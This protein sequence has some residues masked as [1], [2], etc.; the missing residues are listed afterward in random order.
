MLCRVTTVAKEIIAVVIVVLLL[1]VL[2]VRSHNLA[3]KNKDDDEEETVAV[4]EEEDINAIQEH[5][6]YTANLGID[7]KGDGRVEVKE[8]TAQ[9][10]QQSNVQQVEATYGDAISVFDFRKVPDK[11]VDGSSIKDYLK[12]VSAMDFE[13]GWGKELTKADFKTTKL[14]LIGTEQDPEDFEKGDLQSVGWLINNL[15]SF[16]SSDA[17]KFTNLHVV[18]NLS[19]NPKNVLCCY[20]WYSAFGI[21]DTLVM[22]EDISGTVKN[23]DLEA[24]DVFSAVVYKHNMK[25]QKVNGQNVVLVEYN[26]FYE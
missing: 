25:V 10:S 26:T 9:S 18:G 13:T 6:D 20:D 16:D 24:G 14:H 3:N 23:S 7:T 4:L 15:D 11:M 5:S 1:V 21:D 22:F 17:V 19:K 12:S 2:S 8:Q